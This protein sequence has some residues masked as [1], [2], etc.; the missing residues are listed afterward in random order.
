[1]AVALVEQSKAYATE[2]L[3]ERTRQAQR[4]QEVFQ[5]ALKTEANQTA[6]K[7]ML[8]QLIAGSNASPMPSSHHGGGP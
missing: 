4:D 1:M 6:L 8:Q 5:R 7:G 2:A 3:E